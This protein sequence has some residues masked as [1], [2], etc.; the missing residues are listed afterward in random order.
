MPTVA[1]E[2]GFAVSPV[3]RWPREVE[4]GRGYV[5]TVD[6]VVADHGADW[7]YEQEELAV[8]CVIDGGSVWTVESVGSSTVVLHRFGGS[9]GSVSFVVRAASGRPGVPQPPRLTMVSA[10]GV[11]FHTVEL[12]TRVTGTPQGG[13]AS[14]RP[15]VRP[16]RPLSVVVAPPAR[17]RRRAE[18]RRIPVVH[19]TPDPVFFLSHAHP[20][21]AGAEPVREMFQDLTEDLTQ[22]LPLSTGHDPGFVDLEMRA[23]AAWREELRSAIGSCQVFVP[24][25][26]ASYL[27]SSYWHAEWDTFARR[28]VYGRADGY[29]VDTS[30]ILPVLWTPVDRERV[31]SMVAAV[32]RFTPTGLPDEYIEQYA[33]QGLYGMLD[34]GRGDAYRSVVWRL[35]RAIQVLFARN[36]V[37]PDVLPTF[38]GSGTGVTDGSP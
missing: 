25:L 31:P 8:G 15:A 5:V 3:V 32:A 9:Y 1:G 21:A 20:S 27:D 14:P 6:V 36:W 17:P 12:P 22:L 35:A 7:P 26:S 37:E 18:R 19:D 13:P 2:E 30:A 16:P 33:E 24:L 28:R 11:P 10:G 34:A 29:R 4:P 23:G 38:D